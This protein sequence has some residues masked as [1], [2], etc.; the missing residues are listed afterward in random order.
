M[1]PI[2]PS[3]FYYLVLGC[4]G[5]AFSVRLSS[6]PSEPH[7]YTPAP[8]KMLNPAD[9]RCQEQEMAA[10]KDGIKKRALRLCLGTLLGV[11][12]E[13]KPVRHPVP[14]RAPGSIEGGRYEKINPARPVIKP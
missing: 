4:K 8:I 11:K 13:K 12:Y 5:F 7:D 14:R 1:L 10:K 2:D 3:Y 6:I 9:N